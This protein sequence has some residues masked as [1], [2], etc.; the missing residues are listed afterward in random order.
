M[1][2]DTEQKLTKIAADRAELVVLLNENRALRDGFTAHKAN[3]QRIVEQYTG[4]ADEAHESIQRA[5][6]RED[7]LVDLLA[8]LEREERAVRIEN[9]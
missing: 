7:M 3:C 9:A 1:T 4:F 8:H 2:N 5:I 6:S